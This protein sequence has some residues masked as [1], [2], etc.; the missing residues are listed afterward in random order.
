MLRTDKVYTGVQEDLASLPDPGS[1]ARALALDF[2][3]Q[4]LG[5]FHAHDNWAK[6]G[7]EAPK[8]VRL[9]L[10]ASGYSA[11]LAPQVVEEL[12]KLFSTRQ[13][14]PTGFDL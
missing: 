12:Q 1:T 8:W 5:Q 3:E 14:W 4:R 7:P 11:D 6:L 10:E 13:A 2:V 9:W